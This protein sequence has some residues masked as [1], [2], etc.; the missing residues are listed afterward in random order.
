MLGILVAALLSV[1]FWAM[2][3]TDHRV[4]AQ[5]RDPTPTFDI[6]S[7]Y[8]YGSFQG[9]VGTL[10]NVKSTSAWTHGATI[11]LSVE[12]EGIVCDP[13]TAIPITLS[14]TPITVDA[15]NNWSSA[16]PWP[17]N[18][19]QAGVYHVCANESGSGTLKGTST[20][21]FTV[22]T[23][24]TGQPSAAPAITLSAPTAHSG[25][26]ITVVGTNWLPPSQTITLTLQFPDRT[27][28]QDPGEILGTITSDGTGVF[29]KQVTI[30]ADRQSNLVITGYAG[31]PDAQG[32]FPLLAHSSVIAVGAAPTVTP[33]PPT[34][35]VAPT[36]AAVTPG[37]TST[38]GKQ[39]NESST[40]VLIGLLGLIAAVL[41]GAGIVVA[42]LA[43]RGKSGT[44]PQG[45]NGAA[46]WA[47]NGPR[48]PQQG[49][50]A[51]GHQS[52]AIW[53]ETQAG[54]P[55]GWN[56]EGWQQPRG[57]PWGGRESRPYRGPVQPTTTN[58]YD[59]DED[60]P[61]RTRMGEPFQSQPPAS[62]PAPGGPPMSRPT[63]GMPPRPPTGNIQRRPPPADPNAYWEDGE[64]TDQPTNPGWPQNPPPRR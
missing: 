35:T 49:W 33:L 18:A 40:N 53:D 51:G 45:G 4:H 19:N 7:P 23:S 27:I 48:D 20:H 52:G 31:T 57:Q 41:L 3:P 50:D 44:P 17:N 24:Q 10:V 16:F 47:S 12:P 26:T 25:D 6:I 55:P 21:V 2:Q 11:I 46:D 58:G 8:F 38:G 32:N 42:I 22:W 28:Q 15:T 62:R 36:K 61:Y 30:P 39:S 63:P 9:P 5:D 1:A 34:A 13:T 37:S 29:S 54:S 56:D 59:E 64:S 14:G 43:V 60:D